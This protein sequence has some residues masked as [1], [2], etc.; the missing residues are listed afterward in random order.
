MANGESTQLF[1]GLMSASILLLLTLVLLATLV[2]SA[3]VL[4]TVAAG[5]AALVGLSAVGILA[6]GLRK[7][8]LHPK[9]EQASQLFIRFLYPIALFL[10]R[11][12]GKSRDAIQASFIAVHNR[13]AEL[14]EIQVVP[15]DVL[16]LLPHCMQWHECP[17]RITY[18][19]EQCRRC[20]QCGLA[21]LLNLRDQYGFH[22]AVATGG[23]A[24]R[25]LIQEQRPQVVVAV[26]CERDLAS[27]IQD[28]QQVYVRGVTNERPNGPCFDTQVDIAQIEAVVVEVLGRS[29]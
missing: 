6:W 5:V 18:S 17:Y 14:K 22:L 4:V 25:R 9:I 20:H 21:E 23:S 13:L 12:T 27:G 7:R 19:V 3:W 24:A 1:L 8:A 28:V 10:G 16:V 29:E 2:S 15:E 11:V 26:A